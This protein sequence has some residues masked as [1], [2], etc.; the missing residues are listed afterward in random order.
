MT[1]QR[2]IAGYHEAGHASLCARLG[3]RIRR[4]TIKS[5]AGEYAGEV[6]HKQIFRPGDLEIDDDS[7][8]VRLRTERALLITLAGPYAQKRFA[9]RSNWFHR[10][11]TGSLAGDADFDK[12][13]NIVGRLFGDGTDVA[14]KYLAYIK[15]RAARLVD[16]WWFDI[17]AIATA[18]IERGTLTGAQIWE[19]IREARNRQLEELTASKTKG[20][21]Q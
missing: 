4:A 2:Q 12:A 14:R 3:V 13:H 20:K 6:R 1:K 18:L 7:P 10:N 15:A 16:Y 5:C 21:T 19:V 11:R 9:P 8:G 17:E